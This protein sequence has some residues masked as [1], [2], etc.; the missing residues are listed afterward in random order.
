MG[1]KQ[2]DRHTARLAG[3]RLEYLRSL[4]GRT[5]TAVHRSWLLTGKFHRV[6]AD[7]P[8]K[9]KWVRKQHED[10]P[11]WIEHV[12]DGVALTEHGAELLKRANKGEGNA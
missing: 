6:T 9:R 10:Q 5:S 4:L 3:M 11:Q 8:G 12:R 1:R 7:G 2:Y